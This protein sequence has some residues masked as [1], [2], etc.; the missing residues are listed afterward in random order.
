M[1]YSHVN[2]APNR[3]YICANPKCNKDMGSRYDRLKNPKCED[4]FRVG[5]KYY[6]FDCWCELED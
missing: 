2:S 5:D 6:C 3:K 4:V 1:K